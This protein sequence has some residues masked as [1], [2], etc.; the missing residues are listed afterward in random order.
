M[1]AQQRL[2][3]GSGDPAHG[4][5]PD[6]RSVDREGLGLQDH[7]EMLARRWAYVAVP[8]VLVPLMAVVYTMFSAPDHEAESKLLIKN[9]VF[10]RGVADDLLDGGAYVRSTALHTLAELEEVRIGAADAITEWATG[11]DDGI[12]GRLWGGSADGGGP[13]YDRKMTSEERAFLTSK[14]RVLTLVSGGLNVIPDKVDEK[15][16]IIAVSESELVAAAAADGLAAAIVQMFNRG[17][18]ERSNLK[19]I[20]DS[21]EKNKRKL[22]DVNRRIASLREEAAGATPA[23]EAL[24]LEIERQYD[25]LKQHEL[26]LRS[27]GYTIEE[28]RKTIEIL[29]E[30]AALAQGAPPEDLVRRLID[31]ELE[32]DQARDRYTEKH[33]KMKKL[34]EDIKRA[35]DMIR[36]YPGRREKLGAGVSG[37]NWR[38]GAGVQ[39]ALEKAKLAGIEA[40]HKEFRN[41]I[42]A[43]RREIRTNAQKRDLKYRNLLHEQEV[44]QGIAVDLRTRYHRAE[45]AEENRQKEA[46]GII[47]AVPAVTRRIGPGRVHVVTLA[48]VVGLLAGVALAFIAERLDETVRFPAEMRVLTGLPTLQVV[49]EFR[50]SLIIRPEETVSAIANAFA[51]LRNNIRYSAP[52]SPERAILITSAVAN[53]G[54][55]LIAV[56]LAISFAQEGNR[57]CLVDADIQK[58]ERH[59]MEE[60]VKLAWEPAGGLAGA[61]EG[62]TGFELDKL[63]IP[64]VE[65]TNL[66]YVASGGRAA[67]PPRALRSDRAQEIFARLQEDFDCLVVDSPPVLPVVDA[68][69]LACHCRSVIQIVRYGYTRRSELEESVRR[70]RH[71][72]APVVGLVLN[73]ARAGAGG[74]HY[75][76]YPAE[77]VAATE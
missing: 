20:R 69:V 24:P 62:A 66:F 12:L 28:S 10:G 55:S 30:Q 2:L 37:L 47:E 11:K 71:V 18:S 58:G 68:A 72:G 36:E 48:L 3:T 6:G 50:R 59:A 39:L 42:D 33:P 52:G 15:L 22:E 41:T 60:A 26:D 54:K 43:I 4:P 25:L 56:N 64:S 61:L 40:R 32:R 13:R 53:E 45:L 70:L 19:L 44:L 73:C 31:L 23:F 51:V 49:P 9:T 57:T 67:N 74:Y 17:R 16:S 5:V 77:R 46:G 75:E 65:L 14:E 27:L 1:K 8:L 29:R 76:R 35:E 34:A 7:L 21:L 63:A 38:Y